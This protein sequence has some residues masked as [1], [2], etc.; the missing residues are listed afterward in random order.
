MVF[1]LLRLAGSDSMDILLGKLVGSVVLRT[2]RPRMV[3]RPVV[4]GSMALGPVV[5]GPVVPQALL[6][7]P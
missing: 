7:L 3:L 5:L 2:L 1:E 6:E 4:L